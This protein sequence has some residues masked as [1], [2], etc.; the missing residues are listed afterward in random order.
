MSN[1]L[2]LDSHLFICRSKGQV[3]REAYDVQL[4]CISM[5]SLVVATSWVWKNSLSSDLF[6]IILCLILIYSYVVLRARLDEGPT[7][8]PYFAFRCFHYVVA[9]NWV[10][11]NSVSSDLFL[12]I[13]YLILIYL[14]VVWRALWDE[15][16]TMC[17][18]FVFQCFHYRMAKTWVLWNLV[19]LFLWSHHILIYFHV[20]WMPHEMKGLGYIVLHIPRFFTQHGLL[21][22]GG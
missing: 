9:T 2:I 12:I 10:W 16:P 14:Y 19:T 7:M 20:I 18:Y 11:Q 13:L 6:L 5:F 15:R 17:C 21:E 4:S 8:P 3:R 22:L 1:N